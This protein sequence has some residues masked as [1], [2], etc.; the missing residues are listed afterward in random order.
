MGR[1]KKNNVQIC[2]RISEG[3]SNKLAQYCEDAGQSKGIAVERALEMY[4]ENYYETRLRLSL[5]AEER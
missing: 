3:V 4:I 5:L 2:V 1:E